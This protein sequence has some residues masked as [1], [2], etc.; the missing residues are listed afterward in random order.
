M[1]IE[2]RRKVSYEYGSFKSYFSICY[3]LTEYKNI[4]ALQTFFKIIYY[5][6]EKLK[7]S[8]LHVTFILVLSSRCM[9]KYSHIIKNYSVYVCM[10]I[11]QLYY[12]IFNCIF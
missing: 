5:N 1:S 3:K 11:S 6:L 4:P 8:Y 9:L 10:Y 7:Q 2:T 12:F